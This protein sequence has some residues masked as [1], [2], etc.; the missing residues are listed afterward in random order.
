MKHHLGVAVPVPA[1]VPVPA[2]VVIVEAVGG[3]DV[4]AVG[5]ALEPATGDVK[6]VAATE[7]SRETKSLRRSSGRLATLDLGVASV[8]SVGS[9]GSEGSGTV[10]GTS[11]VSVDSD[12][13]VSLNGCPATASSEASTVLLNVTFRSGSLPGPGEM[14]QHSPSIQMVKRS[15]AGI[16]IS[17]TAALGSMTCEIALSTVS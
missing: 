15:Q 13:S 11:E 7:A 10:I 8:V 16:L 3:A 17:T 4:G 1:P 9:S 14:V 12:C 6:T 2:V 5:V